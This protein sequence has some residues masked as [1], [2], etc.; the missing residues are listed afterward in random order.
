MDVKPLDYW[1]GT[2]CTI[3]TQGWSFLQQ[4][5]VV[6][7]NNLTNFSICS[8]KSPWHKIMIMQLVYG[9]FLVCCIF[10]KSDWL[11]CTHVSSICAPTKYRKT[12]WKC[13]QCSERVCKDHSVIT[14]SNN[15]QQLQVTNITQ[16]TFIHISVLN[17][18]SCSQK[19]LGISFLTVDWEKKNVNEINIFCL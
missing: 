6:R 10:F 9:F 1:L 5:S 2:I 16:T 15:K 7:S 14:N 19:I 4:F 18:F 8:S 13:C 17:H 3:R 12:D 11:F